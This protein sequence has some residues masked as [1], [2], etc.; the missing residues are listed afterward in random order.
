MKCVGVFAKSIVCTEKN[1]RKEADKAYV[2][3]TIRGFKMM[4]GALLHLISMPH[5]C[6]ANLTNLGFADAMYF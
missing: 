6:Q 1:S 3:S 5:H 4:L 2:V